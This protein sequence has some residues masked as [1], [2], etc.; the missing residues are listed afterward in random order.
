MWL[1]SH[2]NLAMAIGIGFA[3]VLLVFVA[4]IPIYQNASKLL[5][6][7]KQKSIELEALTNKVSILSQLDPNVLQERVVVLDKA[8]PPRK[9]ILLYLSSIDGLSRE[10]DSP[11]VNDP[12]ARV[13]PRRVLVLVRRNAKAAGLQNLE[14]EIK[15]RGSEENVYAFLRKVEEV[16]P[17]MQIGDIKVSILGEDQYSLTLKLGMLWA[18]PATADVKSQVTLFGEK[19]EKYFS[20][21]ASYRQFEPVIVSASSKSV[22]KTDLFAPFVVGTTIPQQ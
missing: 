19:E 16:L 7:I 17:L 3:A 10:L 22:G 14:T 6:Q 11:L 12:G 13:L 2:K 18:E 20:Q 21:L 15:M 5:K 4:M 8:L 9:D 1:N